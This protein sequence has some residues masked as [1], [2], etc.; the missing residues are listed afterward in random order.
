MTTA[1]SSNEDQLENCAFCHQEGAKNHCIPCKNSNAEVVYCGRECQR[2]HWKEH[3]KNCLSVEGN[4]RKKDKDNLA[5]DMATMSISSKKDIKQL[6]KKGSTYQFHCAACEQ[7]TNSNL[8]CSRCKGV[9]YCC[10]DCQVKDWPAHKAACIKKVADTAKALEKHSDLSQELLEVFHH[11]R[12]NSTYSFLKMIRN[13]YPDTLFRQQP[14]TSILS[15][16][17]DYNW[18]YKTFL[19]SREPVPILMADLPDNIKP[20]IEQGL[21]SIAGKGEMG[22]DGERRYFHFL[23]LDYKGITALKPVAIPMSERDPD[24]TLLDLALKSN[25]VKLPNAMPKIQ[26]HQT[27][28]TN[29]KS[30]IAILRGAPDWSEF[31]FMAMHMKT[32]RPLHKTHCVQIEFEYGFPLGQVSGLSSFEI[33][34]IKKAR[35]MFSEAKSEALEQCLNVEGNPKLLASR[36]RYPRNIQLAVLLTN[37][38]TSHV[39]AAAEMTEYDSKSISRISPNLSDREAASRFARLQASLQ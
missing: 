8:V 9:T 10:R 34:P 6:L 35:Q 11:W 15:V 2:K 27:I 39:F 18:N 7:E 13:Y 5:E 24:N 1:G 26:W 29:L 12:N 32:K 37:K 3:R 16:F 28:Q 14:P 25:T 31:L 19:P 20:S 33:L 22:N 4:R 21:L 36:H 23:L 38:M 17:L 30:Q